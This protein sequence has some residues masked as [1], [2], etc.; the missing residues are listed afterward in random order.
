MATTDRNGIVQ[1]QQSDAIE[2]LEAA[3][4]LVS[5]SVSQA[6]DGNVRP[7]TVANQTARNTLATQRPPTA[8]APLLV[9]RSDLKAFE[10][11]SG[12]GWAT[13]PPESATPSPNSVIIDGTTYAAS[14]SIT[15]IPSSPAFTNYQGTYVRTV[16]LTGP[17]VPPTGWYFQVWAQTTTGF[18]IVTNTSTA[19][20][21]DKKFN[22]RHIQVGNN[23]V[24]AMT[25]VGW[26]LVK[27]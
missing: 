16:A 12:S 11:N 13:W 19:V 1:L 10:M 23:R 2:P 15:S 6:F 7:F 17:Y 27:A 5:A 26:R 4:N 8:T 20:G 3:I 9:W 14:G 18:T 24:S 21:S 22:V 25:R